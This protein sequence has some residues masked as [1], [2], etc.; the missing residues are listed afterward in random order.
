MSNTDTT[1][2]EP[3]Q[4]E[5]DVQQLIDIIENN[6]GDGQS[7]PTSGRIRIK[8]ALHTV[9]SRRDEEAAELVALRERAQVLQQALSSI[10]LITFKP[11]YK[12]YGLDAEEVEEI[13]KLTNV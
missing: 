11:S 4:T 1:S 6:L 5:V 7:L 2:A 13:E 10:S 3:T 9:L 8:A 12:G